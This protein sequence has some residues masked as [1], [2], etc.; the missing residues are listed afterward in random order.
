M[1]EKDWKKTVSES[2]LE[3]NILFFFELND[4]LVQ[5]AELKANTVD[6]LMYISYQLEGYNKYKMNDQSILA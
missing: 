4:S 5:D 6:R 1:H 2:G 3:L